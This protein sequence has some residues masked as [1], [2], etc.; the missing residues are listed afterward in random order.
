M[1]SLVL[2]GRNDS[3]GYN[4]HKRAALSLNCMAEV[5]TDPSDEI[6]FVDYNT[7]DDFPTFPEAIQDTLTKRARGL[8]RILR[9]RPY[10]HERFKSRTHL[11]AL[12]PV[13]RNVAI[14]RSDPSNRWILSTNTD[15]IFVPRGGRSLSEITADLAPGFY[16]APRIEIPEVLWESLDRSAPAEIINTVR[17]W[18][19]AL[20]LNEII[21][22][23]KYI[24]YDGPGDFQLLLRSDLFE[25]QGFHEAML[26]GWHVDSNIAKRMYI[27]YGLV[28][29]LGSQVYG[30][31]CD[32]TRQVTPAHSHT[33]LQNDWRTF[34]D[35]VE[36][37]DIPELAETWGCVNDTIEELRLVA[38]PASVYVQGLRDAIG[39]PLVEAPIVN[40]IIETYNKVSY[41]PRHVLPFLADMFVSMPRNSNL[42]WYGAG[43]EMLSR[44]AALWEKLGFIGKIL[45]DRDLIW[46]TDSAGAVRYVSS[47][48][49][50]DGAD[51]FVFDFGDLP[52]SPH[53]TR[54]TARKQLSKE[55]LRRF[56]CVVRAERC[57]LSDGSGMPSRRIIALNAINNHYE[58]V[59]SA[60]VA[61][62][63]TPCATHMRHG[64]VLA[65][66]AKYDWLPLLV[67]GQAGIRSGDQ[68]KTDANRLGLIIHGPYKYLDEGRYRLSI[69]VELSAE[70]RHRPGNE[71]C[72]A[73]EARVGTDLL[74]AYLIKRDAL[75]N[76][77][78]ELFFVVSPLAAGAL[79]L[80]DIRLKLLVPVSLSIRSVTVEAA[81]AITKERDSDTAADLMPLPLQIEDW[82]PY[83]S[84]GS[85][86]HVEPAGVAA[87]QGTS[88]YVVFGPYWPLPAG[89]YEM[90]A[91]I[92][93]TS[94]SF[95]NGNLITA[96]VTTTSGDCL[97]SAEL[98]LD[99]LGRDYN[100]GQC[101]LRL[102]FDVPS[103]NF[104]KQVI[105]TRIWSSGNAQFKFRS[106]S[107]APT[108][109]R[110]QKHLYP[111]L[112]IAEGSSWVADDF[113]DFDKQVGFVN[114]RIAKELEPGCY[115]LAFQ[116]AIQPSDKVALGKEQPH[117]IALA[118]HRFEVLTFTA[119][120]SENQDVDHQL[121]FEVP[122]D[123]ELGVIEFLFQTVA[124]GS[125]SLRRL[126]LERTATAIRSSGAEVC[127]LENW[128]PFLRLRPRAHAD[129][130]GIVVSKGPDDFAV[131]GPFWTLPPGRYNMIA[132]IVPEPTS[133]ADNPIITG[134][135]VAD[136]GS[137]VFATGTWRLGQFQCDNNDDA[138]EMRVPFTLSD[139]L[140]PESRTIET[141]IYSP[142]NAS[143]RLRS[144]AV[145]IRSDELEHDWFPYLTIGDY[146]IHTGREI[147]TIQ[148]KFGLIASTPP[149]AV[150]P[151]HYKLLPQIYTADANASQGDC[152]AL[153][154]W[155]GSELIAIETRTPDNDQPLQFSATD[156]IAKRVVEVRIRVMAPSVVAIRGLTVEKTSDTVAP[157]PVPTVWRL[158]DWRPF[159]QTGPR[160]HPD[161]NDLVVSEGRDEF[162][163]YGPHWTLPAGHY[164]MIA[165]IVPHLSSRD[166]NPVVTGQVT[167]NCGKRI[168]AAA[169]CRLGQNWDGPEAVTIRVPFT[170]P[171]DVP[172]ESRA[173]ETRIFA[174]GNAS[175]RIQSIVVKIGKPDRTWIWS[176][177]RAGFRIRSLIGAPLKP[178]K[179]LLTL[180]RH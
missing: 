145:R 128:L 5:L 68:I 77:D 131:Y 106:L 90:T 42:G 80:V 7:P 82:L 168:F 143:F 25:N 170:L 120:T 107:V 108:G 173:I 152:I 104:D 125:L 59:V 113:R 101:L 66:K 146:G 154:L 142:S 98:S 115:R 14:R 71:P 127:R 37:P 132:S 78:H 35:E 130:D 138:I 96:D 3:Y 150:A 175:F 95:N 79:D 159:L 166:D 10:V 99:M 134:Q 84:I 46:R 34:C 97:V 141:R 151:G 103:R 16:H 44:F 58:K 180:R 20:H 110:N 136:E 12:E 165:T 41:D 23:A 30:Y 17:E 179:S 38:E 24:L 55:L 74:S 32:H 48:E 112:S 51:T 2:Y 94:D 50:L 174:P 153:E 135:V 53:Q 47:A 39:Q 114:Y 87:R 1:I 43:W 123:S 72:I 118:K 11:V 105:E 102:P 73:V 167:G 86:G 160:V 69:K 129:P 61:A 139:K 31:H 156:D 36:R 22:G 15:M 57:R 4:L 40:Y 75:R 92:E 111:F 124:V 9:V 164:E 109:E 93:A 81:P 85:L 163:V 28:G 89:Q 172:A 122:C 76:P 18:G 88:D 67:I 60:L 27:K 176:G 65:A 62:A 157:N 45:V 161:Q 19:S 171:D 70:D 149:M 49:I 148:N 100:N 26:L 147:K 169:E 63:A 83:L 133:R 13:A 52:G 137:L 64:Y 178:L 155:A 117:I 56:C 29:D 6:L 116:V 21:L 158:N 140:L 126:A 121:L 54:A 177:R 8:L 119:I 144:L 91:K 162:V 33:R